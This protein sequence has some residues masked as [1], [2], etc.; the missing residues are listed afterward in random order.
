MS[1]LCRRSSGHILYTYALSG[2]GQQYVDV[3]V[4]IVQMVWCDTVLAGFQ[5]VTS[6]KLETPNSCVSAL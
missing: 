2:T 5:D 4:D 6:Y 1:T 3:D